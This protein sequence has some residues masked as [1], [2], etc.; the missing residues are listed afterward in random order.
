ML[1]FQ[2]LE[3]SPDHLVGLPEGALNSFIKGLEVCI[4]PYFGGV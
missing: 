2:L 1:I 3:P 4:N